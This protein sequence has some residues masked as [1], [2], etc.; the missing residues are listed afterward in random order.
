MPT[1]RSD[2]FH[3]RCLTNEYMGLLVRY[4]KLDTP[5]TSKQ[6]KRLRKVFGHL[7]RAQLD[8]FPK[9]PKQVATKPKNAPP[10]ARDIYR[11][12]RTITEACLRNPDLTRLCAIDTA[13]GHRQRDSLLRFLS[14]AL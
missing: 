2:I 1:N 12:E 7:Q 8:R 13:P 3:L 14:M 4:Q 6:A 11:S 5:L 10:T 9:P